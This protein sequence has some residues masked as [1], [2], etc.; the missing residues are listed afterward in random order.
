MRIFLSYKFTGEDPTVLH[1]LLS[2][3]CSALSRHD[4]V[5]T[6]FQPEMTSLSQE[7]A[8]AHCL[9][10]LE[11]PFDAL[12]AI[13]HTQE[14][15]KG[16]MLEIQRARERNI[17]ILL[18]VQKGLDFHHLHKEAHQVVEFSHQV[19]LHEKLKLI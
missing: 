17:P 19:E 12:V 6:F 1:A 10:T 7:E 8:Y 9:R 14:E 5:C 16:M 15:S 11:G 2:Q 13:V 18:A 3:A 4:V